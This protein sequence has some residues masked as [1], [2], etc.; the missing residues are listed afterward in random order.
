ML[1]LEI[2]EGYI[3]QNTSKYLN[4]VECYLL[5]GNEDEESENFDILMWWKVNLS[6][7][8]VLSQVA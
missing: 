3:L 7:Y 2:Q 6:K 4:D 5:D 1:L 8:R